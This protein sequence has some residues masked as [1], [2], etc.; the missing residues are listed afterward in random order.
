VVFQDLVPM[1]IGRCF[2]KGRIKPDN[3]REFFMDQDKVVS[4]DTDCLFFMDLIS[5]FFVGY[6]SFVR[7]L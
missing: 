3:Y 2:S 5:L 6:S 1:A 4:Q 7:L